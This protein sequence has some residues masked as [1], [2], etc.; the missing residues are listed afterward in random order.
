MGPES[1]GGVV[2]NRMSKYSLMVLG[3]TAMLAGCGDNPSRVKVNVPPVEEGTAVTETPGYEA[4]PMVS[5]DGIWVVFEADVDGDMEIYRIPVGGG[6]PQ[7]LTD[8][9]DFD[10]SP[11]WSPDG[12]LIAFESDRTGRKHIYVL[13]PQDPAGSVT[14][15]TA[16]DWDD[17][18]PAWSPLGGWIAFESNRNKI[19]GTDIY[20]V[21]E[22][23]TETRRVT[24][25]A[26]YS[27]SRSA[28]W[29]PQGSRLVFESNRTGF[30]ALF[31]VAVTGG[32]A[33]Q[34]TADEGYEGHPA[35]SPV[36]GRIAFESTASGS[37][38][39][40][41]VGETGGAWTQVTFQGGF[42]PQW[43]A[44]GDALVYCVYDGVNA[45]VRIVPVD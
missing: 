28:D 3:G 25:T 7:Q 30:S 1:Q 8:N 11:C 44:A 38:Q 18:S 22:D 19:Q 9:S 12:S 42:W 23:G 34:I 35:W 4:N 13:D 15:L 27:Y 21:A 5:P 6:E 14:A 31:T 29:S 32:A 10:S 26:D 16:G 43:T 45:D 24:E 37:S 41:L 33:V 39:I 17:G 40:H 2:V 20:L 36:G